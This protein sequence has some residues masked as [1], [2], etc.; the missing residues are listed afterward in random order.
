MESEPEEA[1]AAERVGAG[2]GVVAACWP[3]ALPGAGDESPVPS[4]PATQARTAA[5]PAPPA[6]ASTLARPP[7]KPAVFIPVNRS[8]E[9]QVRPSSVCENWGRGRTSRDLG[10][11]RHLCRKRRPPHRQQL[12]VPTS[13]TSSAPAGLSPWTSV[14]CSKGPSPCL[15]LPWAV[16]PLPLPSCQGF[17]SPMDASGALSMCQLPALRNH[18]TLHSLALSEQSPLVPAAILQGTHACTHTPFAE[19]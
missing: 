8:P 6:A 18:V 9:M 16:A 3:P 15:C 12:T 4:G 14:S 5:P 7:A 19:H 2:A 17:C 13:Q 10:R 11:S 1:P